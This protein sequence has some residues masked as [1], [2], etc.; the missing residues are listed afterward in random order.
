VSRDRRIVVLAL[1]TVYVAW[2]ATYPAIAVVVR[3][4]PPLL[5]MGARFLTAGLILLVAL[6]I[7][8]RRDSATPR[9][10]IGSTIVGP[11]ILGSIG[12]I[13][14]AEVHVD[15]G[16]AALLIGSVPLWVVILMSVQ[17]R[18]APRRT[19][20]LACVVGFVGLGLVVR[21]GSGSTF[22]WLVVLVGAALYEASGE[23]VGTRI[24]Q[25]ADALWATVWQL[26]GAGAA[27]LAAGLL[28]GE[29][30]AVSW[31]RIGAQ[32][33]WC[34]AFLVLVG[35]VLAYP[36]LVWLLANTP[37]STASTY[38]YVNPVV[39]LLLGGVLLGE[40]VSATVLIGA[41]VILASVA[42][43]VRSDAH[44]PQGSA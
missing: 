40:H 15:S 22:W 29:A 31:H 34:F 16:L 28:A 8:G 12:V 23:V 19:V 39:A 1:A 20:L 26:L 13:A 11:W 35:S 17:R 9:Q 2:G 6:H 42:V 37:T 4:V 3:T 24:S 36:A 44:Q 43:V 7:S 10:R 38:A 25:P 32:T 5:A 41:A 21:P 18:R 14:I 33:W 30:S 27:L